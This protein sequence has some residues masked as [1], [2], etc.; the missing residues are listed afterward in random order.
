MADWQT[1]RMAQ[2]L[3]GPREGKLPDAQENQFQTFMAMDPNVRA[4]R[5]G[6]QNQYGEQPNMNDP[7]FNYREAFVAGNRPQPTPFDTIPHWDSRGKSPDHP[8]EWMN[9]FMGK[10]GVD[11]N[12]Q[13]QQG[14]T[15]PQQ[16]MVNGQLSSDL[17][18]QLLQ[19]QKQ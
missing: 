1:Q 18:T 13:A 15:P 12:V 17:L 19:R 6:F 7:N 4:W 9:T 11:P 5:N 10:F 8:T 3:M 14:F 2:L 16:N